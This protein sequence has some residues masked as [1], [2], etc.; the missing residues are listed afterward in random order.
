MLATGA[1]N[2]RVHWLD[3]QTERFIFS[4]RIPS[5]AMG[6]FSTSTVDADEDAADDEQRTTSRKKQAL[7]GIAIL[8]LIAAVLYVVFSRVADADTS[9][10]A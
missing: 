2:R 3:A 7:I 9:D 8:V 10:G 4:R 1:P 5:S 6:L